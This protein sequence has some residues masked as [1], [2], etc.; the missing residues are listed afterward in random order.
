M[1]GTNVGLGLRLIENKGQ[2]TAQ[3]RAVTIVRIAHANLREVTH[4]TTNLHRLA[5]KY[6]LG[7]GQGV[8]FLNSDHT[9]VRI[10]AVIREVPLL[11][12]FPVAHAGVVLRELFVQAIEWVSKCEITQEAHDALVGLA[13]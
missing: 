5:R 6:Q 2:W 4:N 13:A 1:Q 7:E 12:L 10:V 3:P 9:R 11:I 8:V